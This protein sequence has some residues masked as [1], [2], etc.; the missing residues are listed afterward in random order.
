MEPSVK[1]D[2]DL[3][4]YDGEKALADLGKAEGLLK[5]APSAAKVDKARLSTVTAVKITGKKK[6]S[7]S[8]PDEVETEGRTFKVTA[9]DKKAFQK[10]CTIATKMKGKQLG[11]LKKDL[12]KR[13]VNGKVKHAKK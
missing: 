2:A 10:N 13:G 6:A 1:K 7:V 4:D 9:I 8:I 12:K 3:A 5:K 11:K